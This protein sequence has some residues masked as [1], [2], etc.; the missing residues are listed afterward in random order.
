[1]AERKE[2]IE[3]EVVPPLEWFTGFS[4]GEDSGVFLVM[5]SL[6][7]SQIDNSRVYDVYG[8]W[9]RI[10]NQQR[11]G[12]LEISDERAERIKR[13]CELYSKM[14]IGFTP[15]EIQTYASSLT[16]RYFGE[17]DPPLKIRTKHGVRYPNPP[18]INHTS[19]LP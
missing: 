8:E 11:K 6:V 7:F 17:I 4:Y 13:G 19:L 16:D 9:V 14:R 10:T 18:S 2:A 15:K 12:E 1:M 5:T 3:G